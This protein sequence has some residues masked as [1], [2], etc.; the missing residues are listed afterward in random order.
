MNLSYND[1]EEWLGQY[2]SRVAG[3]PMEVTEDLVSAGLDSLEVYRLVHEFESWLKVEVDASA[4]FR[5]QSIREI[6]KTVVR[7]S[8][9]E[10]SSEPEALHA[11]ERWVNPYL[12]E[13]IRNLRLNKVFVRGEGSFLWDEDGE[14]Y[15]DCLA[16]YGSVPF[17]HNPAFVWDRVSQFRAEQRPSIVQPSSLEEAGALAEALL[18]IAPPGLRY[19]T[20]ANSGAEAVEAAIKMARMATGRFGCLTTRG[21]FHGKTLGA[22]SATGNPR[23]QEGSG[24]PVFGFEQVAF[25]DLDALRSRLVSE[26]GRFGLFLVEPIQGEG[27]VVV[28]PQDYLKEAEA[29]CREH[30]VLFAVDE[31][32]TGLGRTGHLFAVEKMGVQPDILILAKALGGGLVPAGAVL[33]SPRAYSKDFALKHSS[34]FAGNGFACAVARAV[35]AELTEERIQHVRLMGDY[36]RR[37][38]EEVVRSYPEVFSEVRGEGLLLGIRLAAPTADQRSVFSLAS[39][40]G[41]YSAIVSSH[42]LNA[43]KVR[44]APTLNGQDVV[45]VEPPLNISLEECDRVLSAFRRTARVLQSKNAGLCMEEI[46]TGR[47]SGQPGAS[48][49]GISPSDAPS[50]E[51]ERFAFLV[52]PL[53]ARDYALFDRSLHNLNDEHLGELA[54]A[55]GGI[56]TPFVGGNI[57]VD[58]PSGR[59]ATGEIVVIPKTASELVALP[60]RESCRLIRTARDLAMDRG[61]RVVGLGGYNSISTRGGRLVHASG[62]RVTNGNAYT[63][64]T[65]IQATTS[66]LEERG[67]GWEGTSVAVLGAGGSVGGGLLILSLMKAERLFLVGNPRR[68]YREMVARLKDALRRALRG[69]SAQGVD[70]LRTTPGSIAARLV[71]QGYLPLGDRSDQ[72]IDLAL[73]WLEKEGLIMF[74]SHPEHILPFADVVLAATSTPDK[75][76]DERFLKEKAV[77]CDVSRPRNLGPGVHERR[78]DV[79]AFDGGLVE[80]P[81]GV[82]LPWLGLPPSEVYACLGETILLALE[83]S[84]ELPPDSESNLSYLLEMERVADLHAFRVARLKSFGREVLASQKKP[85][86]CSNG[87]EA[88]A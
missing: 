68:E 63:V 39:R 14:E 65:A 8:P 57:A 58:S 21:G 62:I 71:R 56:V 29:L 40:E 25:G 50:A 73:A 45:R 69:L 20:F 5:C 86:S 24:A 4:L 84:L 72:A 38:L 81:G 37:G 75:V 54:D 80:V 60:E 13:L 52:H 23:Y 28:P 67:T 15:L 70:S 83:P 9:G 77:V 30:G 33:A 53:Q 2:V 85:R 74:A 10:G 55:L 48:G 6:A 17:G 59:L 44:V 82:N 76:I 3:R 41:M 36:L 31:V 47:A 78:P 27:G 1:I 16:G 87:V 32:Q 43:S 51:P 19:V 26:R 42:L 88:R 11:F 66:V 49:F 64:V 7:E 22:L 61:A 79:M 34:T 35:V 12:G 46:M 18:R